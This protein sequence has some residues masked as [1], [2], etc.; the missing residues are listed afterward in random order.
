MRITIT[1]NGQTYPIMRDVAHCHPQAVHDAMG[2]R[3]RP[4]YSVA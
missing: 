4:S 2:R 3:P 1:T